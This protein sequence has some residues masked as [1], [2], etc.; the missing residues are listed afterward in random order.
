M[1]LPDQSLER[2]IKLYTDEGQDVHIAM[3][4]LTQEQQAMIKS[5]FPPRHT[6]EVVYLRLQRNLTVSSVFGML[7][8]ET[9]KWIITCDTPFVSKDVEQGNYP[10]Q[11]SPLRPSNLNPRKIG[12]PLPRRLYSAV[13][14]PNNERIYYSEDSESAPEYNPDDT[15]SVHSSSSDITRHFQEARKRRA[16]DLGDLSDP[17]SFGIRPEVSPARLPTRRVGY[18]QG[19]MLPEHKDEEPQLTLADH[20]KA[21]CSW[22]TATLVAPPR[23][24]DV[25][26]PS[27]STEENGE[28][29]VNELLAR[30][31]VS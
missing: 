11:A 23:R 1:D 26:A 27:Q 30:W 20:E 5:T 31:T 15:Q 10:I 6:V 17:E 29:I 22:T 25:E 18:G 14:D 16:Q 8:I 28:D 13:V 12:P 3:S 7:S 2:L 24:G 9:L 19:T 21:D 4:E